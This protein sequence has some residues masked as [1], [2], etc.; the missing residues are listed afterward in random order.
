MR[1]IDQTEIVTPGTGRALQVEQSPEDD[2]LRPERNIGGGLIV[3]DV[4]LG[5]AGTIAGRQG[6]ERADPHHTVTTT[7][8]AHRAGTGPSRPLGI[9][10]A[11]SGSFAT[12]RA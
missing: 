8:A 11:E 3:I 10:R 9:H 5:P 2:L 6:D 4:E 7:C 12:N 1:P